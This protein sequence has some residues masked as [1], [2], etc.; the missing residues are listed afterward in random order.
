MIF[1]KRNYYYADRTDKWKV[2]AHLTRLNKSF[3][4]AKSKGYKTVVLVGDPSY[5]S[6][7]GFKNSADLDIRILHDIPEEYVL[8]CELVPG[9]LN[10]MK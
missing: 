5:Y 2:Q 4:L 1:R 9:V 6:W 8:A 7:F 3:E 10:E